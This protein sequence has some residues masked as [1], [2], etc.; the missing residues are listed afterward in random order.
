MKDPIRLDRR[1]FLKTATT[2]ALATSALSLVGGAFAT[3]KKTKW[4]VGCRD[5]HLKFVEPADS[6]A[7]LKRLDAD[8]FEADIND[9][10]ALASFSAPGKQYSVATPDGIALL[11]ADLKV[12]DR[13]ISAFCM[14][15]K[16]DERLD[17][18]IELC[19]ALAHAADQL[20][21]PVIRIDVVPRALKLEEFAAFATKA[22]K[23]L[24]DAT[25]GS[26]I[27]F[28]IENHG[29]ATNDPDLMERILDGVGSDRLGV[30]LDTA[31]LYWWG[32]PLD[33]VYRIYERFAPRVFHT[34]CKSIAYP[35]DKRN[36]KREMGW[37][38]AQR[39]CPVY[40]GDLDFKRIAAVLRKA[41]Y[42]GDLCV[43]N[44]SLGRFPES[45]RAGILQKEIAFLRK[46]V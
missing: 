6:W 1:T 27:R 44:E 30:T 3:E 42:T 16:F 14:H 25:K 18:E 10:L 4:L 38:Y 22:C 37:E 2:A 8:C 32:H 21:V 15:N 5:V 31:N 26:K 23:Q 41:G 13:R 12:N 35:E 29:K 40:D 43:E 11:K 24:C 7:A 20:D 17:R 9:D 19:V 33:D 39:C 45:E 46:L 36:V 34:H 28:G